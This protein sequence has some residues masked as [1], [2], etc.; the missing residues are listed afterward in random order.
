MKRIL[1]FAALAALA[2]SCAQ[3]EACD[4]NPSRSDNQISVSA[5]IADV[6]D[7]APAL[8]SET[9][10]S[11][12]GSTAAWAE[13]DALGL[14]CAEATPAAVNL[15][16]TVT[17]VGSTPV[18]TPSSA[19]Y[20]KDGTT[21][22]KFLAYAPYAAGNTV[23]T[24]VKLPNLGTQT[25][26]M[27]AALDFL[28]SNNQKSGIARTASVGLTFTH[29]LSLVEFQMKIGGG[30]AAGTTLTSFT[31][32]GGASEKLFSAAD[33]TIDLSTAAITPGTA[34]NS[35]TVTPG[36]APTLSATA[37][38]LY[39]MLLPGTY[40][41]PT[42]AINIKEAGTTDFSIPALAIG[43]TQFEAGK[44]YT[45]VV[46]ISR[47]AITISNPTITDWTPVSGGTLNP[48]L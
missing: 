36:T 48:G 2:T 1:C 15:Q 28:I 38:S 7:P 18:W 3:S 46:T 11:Y 45:Y 47:T 8:S 20:W 27:N 35:V 9:R 5:V 23:S 21:L 41:G 42:L 44:K 12:T 39:A 6:S 13:N 29:A 33:A 26:A 43:T 25:G 17:G 22:H 16:Y 10:A 32:A 40:T 31:L 14:F 4:P 19:I 34:T 24:A 30:I 37:T